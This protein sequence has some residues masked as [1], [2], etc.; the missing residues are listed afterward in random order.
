MEDI[1]RFC[2]CL[3]HLVIGIIDVISFSGVIRAPADESFS[4]FVELI[5]IDDW[6]ISIIFLRLLISMIRFII[7]RILMVFI[8]MIDELINVGDLRGS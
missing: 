5:D 3:M 6:F 4:G 8:S 1:V 7:D 2:F